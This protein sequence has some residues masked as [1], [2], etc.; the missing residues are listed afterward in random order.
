MPA[1]ISRN[2]RPLFL[3]VLCASLE[4]HTSHEGVDVSVVGVQ[5]RALSFTQQGLEIPSDRTELSASSDDEGVTQTTVRYTIERRTSTNDIAATLFGEVRAVE[6][7]I[8]FG[9]GVGLGER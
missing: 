5:I 8:H 4:T 2:R 1:M 3:A 6:V 9:I 7:P